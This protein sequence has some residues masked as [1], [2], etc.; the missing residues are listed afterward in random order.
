MEKG[1]GERDEE[2]F[3]LYLLVKILHIMFF[4]ILQNEP[5]QIT[6]LHPSPTQQKACYI[7]NTCELYGSS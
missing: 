5:P 7:Q 4:Q 2:G 6:F 3:T 1:L